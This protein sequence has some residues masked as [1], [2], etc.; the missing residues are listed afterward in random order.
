MVACVTA[1]SLNLLALLFE[2]NTKSQLALLACYIT[3][4]AGLND[5]L[6]WLGVAPVM[7][8]TWGGPFQV[9]RAAMWMFTTPAMV[10]LLSIISDFSKEKVRREGKATK[11]VFPRI[12]REVAMVV[13]VTPTHRV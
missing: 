6:H 4:L 5:C 9:L 2:H 3:F 12:I 13:A 11:L 1:F 10:Y 8:S 7:R